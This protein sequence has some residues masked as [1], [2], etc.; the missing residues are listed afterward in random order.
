[1]GGPPSSPP[2]EERLCRVKAPSEGF[3]M[4]QAS[5]RPGHAPLLVD[6]VNPSP[7]CTWSPPGGRFHDGRWFSWRPGTCPCRRRSHPGTTNTTRLKTGTPEAT[8]NFSGFK[9]EGPDVTSAESCSTP[10]VLTTHLGHVTHFLLKSEES[11]LSPLLSHSW[12]EPVNLETQRK[13][14]VT[15]ERQTR[16]RGPRS[17]WRLQLFP[18]REDGVL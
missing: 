4:P 1:M 12:L 11:P 13:P 18:L 5:M 14:G 8:W 9:Q 10:L 6:L 16:E 15:R 17:V 3:L 2:A 7:F